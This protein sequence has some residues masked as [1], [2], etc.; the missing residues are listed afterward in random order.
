MSPKAGRVVILNGQSESDVLKLVSETIVGLYMPSAWDAA[1]L[2]FT[3]SQ[4]G[5]SFSDVY[6]VGAPLAV[7]AD[8]GQ[9]VPLDFAKFV[10]VSFLK[11]RSETGGAPVNQTADREIIPVFRTLE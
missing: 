4:D 8:A 1:D 9:Y 6:D 3:A 10:G 11:V 5:V 7:Q 2:A